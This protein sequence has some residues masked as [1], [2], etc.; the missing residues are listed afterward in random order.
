MALNE[1]N[2]DRGLDVPQ[3]LSV[4]E[5]LLNVR[6]GGAIE[7]IATQLRTVVA[8]VQNVQKPGKV[9]ITIDVKPNGMNA[10][11]ITD[12]V[13]ATIP[14]HKKQE[15]VFFVTDEFGLSRRD[16]KQPRIPGLRT[17]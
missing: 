16:P 6:E 10:V 14:E 7:E 3:S 9:Q 5:F 1:E 12:A 8:A 11:T 17:L 2:I 13:K 4:T 15:T